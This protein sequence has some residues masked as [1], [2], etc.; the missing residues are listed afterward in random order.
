MTATPYVKVLTSSIK[1]SRVPLWKKIRSTF[2]QC[3]LVLHT[4]PSVPQIASIVSFPPTPR[5]S[6]LPTF[7]GRGNSL[8]Y[9]LAMLDFPQSS[10]NTF[11][12]TVGSVSDLFH[13]WRYKSCRFLWH[14]GSA[15]FVWYLCIKNGH[16]TWLR[17][18]ALYFCIKTRSFVLLFF[19]K[20]LLLQTVSMEIHIKNFL[21]LMIVRGLWF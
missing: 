12:C 7:A 1:K 6:P 10:T 11:S 17:H 4:L 14:W 3:C 2:V 9:R 21:N 15:K 16:W 8:V 20:V 13:L 5:W 19:D 18:F